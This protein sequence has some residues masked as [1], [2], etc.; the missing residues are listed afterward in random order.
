MPANSEFIPQTARTLLCVGP[1]VSDKTH[2]EFYMIQVETP[3]PIPGGWSTIRWTAI[4]AKAIP[5]GTEVQLAS[6]VREVKFE[7]GEGSFRV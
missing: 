4:S 5:V 7:R 3:N 6:R 2:T 1:L